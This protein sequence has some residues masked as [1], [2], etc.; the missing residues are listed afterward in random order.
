MVP[1]I[2]EIAEK[3]LIGKQMKLTF[4]NYNVT[5][6][7]KGFMPKLS[8]IEGKI[9]NDLFSVSVY[10]PTH[11]SNFSPAN[12]FTKWAATEVSDL[13]KIPEGLESFILPGGLYAVFRHKGDYKEFYKTSQF[14][15]GVWLPRSEFVLDDRPHFEVLGEKYKNDD[16]ASEEEVWIPI[17]PIEKP[18]EN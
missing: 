2:R 10:S 12:E 7:W 13:A 9:S 18:S 15:Y 5:E 1:I 11:F 8:A 4:A 6:L 16:P 14:I 17:K 3:K